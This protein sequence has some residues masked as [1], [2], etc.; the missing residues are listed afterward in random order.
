VDDFD[1]MGRPGSEKPAYEPA[2]MGESQGNNMHV[3]CRATLLRSKF[4]HHP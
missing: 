2:I 3:T 1:G 4:V